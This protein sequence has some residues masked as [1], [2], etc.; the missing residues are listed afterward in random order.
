MEIL[1]EDL[2]YVQRVLRRAPSFVLFIA[3]ALALSIGVNTATFSLMNALLQKSLPA[4]HANELVAADD[5]TAHFRTFD[6]PS[7]SDVFS[8]NLCAGLRSANEV[9]TD[10]LVSRERLRI[11]TPCIGQ[12]K[13]ALLLEQLMGKRRCFSAAPRR[14]AALWRSH[15]WLCWL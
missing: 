6:T 3:I 7:R 11:G 4:E 8:H 15:P 5:A 9:S 12:T 10:T 14:I 13:N 1:P 2:H